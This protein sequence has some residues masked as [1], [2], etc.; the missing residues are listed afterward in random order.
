MATVEINYD[1]VAKGTKL[2]VPYLGVFE[3]GS[4]SEVDD[5]K[6]ERFLRNHPNAEALREAGGLTLTTK[7]QKAASAARREAREA[8]AAS[9][10][11]GTGDASPG[12]QGGSG[13]D[14]DAKPL[15]DHNKSDLEEMASGMGIDTEGKKKSEL[16]EAIKAKS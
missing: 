7:A 16:V 12:A 8:A 11:S 2:E 6:W 3:N 10:G 9:E 13:G 15:E 14:T 4:T 1:N 5:V